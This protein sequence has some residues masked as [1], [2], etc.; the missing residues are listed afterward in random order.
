MTQ[1]E[2]GAVLGADPGPG[3]AISSH[4]ASQ[5]QY[6][7][8][9]TKFALV[10][11]NPTLGRASFALMHKDPKLHN[12]Q[13]HTVEVSGVGDQAIEISGPG[14]A[15]IYFTKGDAFVVISVEIPAASS[16]PVD[17]ALALAKLAASRL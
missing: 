10:N 8:Y 3:T 16:P 15:G 9:Q 4:G 13:L 7:S 11:L 6:G 17:Q 5:C 1:N 14:S 2:V 12:A